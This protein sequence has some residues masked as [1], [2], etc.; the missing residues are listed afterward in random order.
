MQ[1]ASV[2][3][4]NQPASD[5]P[6]TSTGSD[7]ANARRAPVA[8]LQRTATL[9]TKVSNS[10]PTAVRGTGNI[11]T[12]MVSSASPERATQG[13]ASDDTD[14]LSLE[15]PDLDLTTPRAASAEDNSPLA[16][17]ELPDLDLDAFPLP[18]SASLE[19]APAAEAAPSTRPTATASAPAA[20][21]DQPTLAAPQEPAAVTG[22]Q[23][24]AKAQQLN[25]QT[26]HIDVVLNGPD[27]L[28]VGMPAH[29]EVQVSNRDQAPLAGLVL[30]LD[31]PA[32]VNAQAQT[33][34]HGQVG[35]ELDGGATMLTWIFDSLP[36][37]QSARLPIEMLASAPR[38]FGVGIEWT[39]MPVTGTL[40]V[41]VLAPQLEVLLE[42]P[43]EVDF[44][45]ANTYR[46][47]IRNPGNAPARTVGV[48]LS[49]EPYGSSS[50]EIGNIPAGGEE[51]V[52]VELTFKQKGSIGI[53]ATAS[54]SNELRSATQIEVLVRQPELEALLEAPPRAY[55]GAPVDVLVQLSNRGDADAHQLMAVVAL[56]AAAEV[57]RMP[58][59]GQWI[60]GNLTWPIPLLAAGKTE[61]QLIQIILAQEGENRLQLNCTNA[62]G[63]AVTCA[64][65]TDVEAVV[66]LKLQV[67]DPIAPAPVGGEVLYELNLTNRGSKAAK[68]VRV[69]AQFSEGIEPIRGTGHACRVIP[70]QLLFDSIP[71][72]EAGQSMTLTVYAKAEKEGAHRFR[73]EVKSSLTDLRL[74]HEES[75]QYLDAPRVATPPGTRSLR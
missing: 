14:Q 18:P 61:Q 52:E 17:P 7:M 38:N 69:I 74:V 29:F 35:S 36:A 67:N 5:L 60:D 16:M 23:P 41:G 72:I 50:T 48:L 58:P 20:R 8:P 19:P 56:P 55:Y 31:V 64:S 12:T 3:T 30:R 51:V 11:P 73:A 66:D 22:L 6:A 57:T 53:S 32:G 44:G 43:A 40:D 71:T 75:T 1:S 13:R 46:L 45:Q 15:L 27:N 26:P 65:T 25:L 24:E 9:K 70:G 49:A 47:R 34:S 54:A 59:G 42:G 21:P 68:D 10:L 33:P 2:P 37:G 28:A 4:T 63:L 62:S 39:L